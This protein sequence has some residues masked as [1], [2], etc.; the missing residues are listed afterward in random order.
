MEEVERLFDFMPGT[1]EGDRL[2]VLVTLYR[3][4]RRITLHY[5][6]AGPG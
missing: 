6:T 4:L 2:E 1:P 5:S 3:S